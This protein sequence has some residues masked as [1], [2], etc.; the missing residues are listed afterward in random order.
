M[1]SKPLVSIVIPAYNA[2][3]YLAEAIDS[4]LEQDYSPAEII[5]VDDGSTDK[6]AAIAQAYSSTS[7]SKTAYGKTIRYSFQ[8]NGGT[9]IARN[10]GVE[11][12]SGDLLAFLDA[13]DVWL[14]D[15]LAR[16]VRA[17]EDHADLE[18]VFGW[19]QQFHSPELT[20][21]E[22]SHV[23]CPSSPM[24]GYLPSALLIRRAAFLRI[25]PFDADLRMSEFVSWYAR[26]M[27]KKLRT[28]MLPTVV[29]RR[30]LHRSNKGRQ[31]VDQQPQNAQL[32]RLL[33]ASLDRR[34]AATDLGGNL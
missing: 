15:K 33:K 10:C 8:K 9:S 26:A 22:R 3:D 1:K 2:Q 32:V 19:V 34:R 4:A 30:R 5:V 28:H 7:Y 18:A 11:M 6:T 20:A 25:G 13:D 21:V 17:L 23:S 31:P 12:A 24:A 14:S 27:E 16:Q 29:A